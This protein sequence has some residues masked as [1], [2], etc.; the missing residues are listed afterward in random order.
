MTF[1][2]GL[3]DTLINDMT[4]IDT[5][6]DYETPEKIKLLHQLALQHVHQVCEIEACHMHVTCMSH[7]CHM[8]VTYMSHACHIHYMTLCIFIHVASLYSPCAGEA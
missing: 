2:M 8:H 4:G 1:P 3:P 6:L 7:T 5:G